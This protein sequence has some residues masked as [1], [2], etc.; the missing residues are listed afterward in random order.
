MHF[1]PQGYGPEIARLLALLEN[2]NRLMPLVCGKC[3]PEDARRELSKHHAADL[4]PGAAEPEAPMAGLWLY[5]SC[6]DEAHKLVDDPRTRDGDYWHAIVH[7]QEPDPGNAGYWF[8]KVGAHPVFEPLAQEAGVI[9]GNHPQVAF[10]SSPWDPFQFIDFCERARK[11]SG[12]AEERAAL[13]IQRSEWQLLFDH[14]SGAARRSLAP[15]SA[16]PHPTRSH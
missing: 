6:F 12:S 14:S 11:R 15:H 9:L 10:N 2:G 7:R 13:E 3:A 16:T 5:F 1:D 4:F 8:R